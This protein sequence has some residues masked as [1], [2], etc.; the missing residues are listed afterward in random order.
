MV[1]NSASSAVYSLL[2]NFTS[3]PYPILSFLIKN[4]GVL[5]VGRIDVGCDCSNVTAVLC[6]L[7]FQ[8]VILLH[9][10]LWVVDGFPIWMILSGLGAHICLSALLTT[11][12]FI[13]ITAP[14]FIGG[15]CKPQTL[16]SYP[17]DI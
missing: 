13:S 10:A 11:F 5:V 15:C 6:I 2:C 1:E 4:R 9:V 12:P 3:H 17:D 14:P 16:H 7:T 8:A